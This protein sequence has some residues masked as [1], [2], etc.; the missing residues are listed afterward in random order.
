M[1]C[2]A[3]TIDA[4]LVAMGQAGA[5]IYGGN[6]LIGPGLGLVDE[7]GDLRPDATRACFKGLVKAFEITA[8]RAGLL[9]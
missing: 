1:Y 7:D 2:G 3:N 4:A 5:T 6:V 9:D 8:R